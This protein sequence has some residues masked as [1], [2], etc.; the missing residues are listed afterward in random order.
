MILATAISMTSRVVSPSIVFDLLETP[1]IY[2]QA[3]PVNSAHIKLP[4]SNRASATTPATERHWVRAKTPAQEL[5][6]AS[7]AQWLC[8]GG[9]LKQHIVL[10]RVVLFDRSA[11]HSVYSIKHQYA[12][13]VSICNQNTYLFVMKF[14]SISTSSV[15]CPFATRHF[16]LISSFPTGGLGCTNVSMP[17][18]TLVIV[19]G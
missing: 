13:L 17:S 4:L 1:L 8:G 7:I 16:D 6:N 14:P 12:G 15:S 10:P 11:R 18:T 2:T 5:H 9:F 3:H 19:S